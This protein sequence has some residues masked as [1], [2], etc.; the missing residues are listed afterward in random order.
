[1]PRAAVVRRDAV[2]L[3]RLTRARPDCLSKE[4][5]RSGP[6]EAP[7]IG[8]RESEREILAKLKAQTRVELNQKA[9]SKLLGE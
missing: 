2:G 5:R 9:W 8:D 7:P 6:A 3:F 4:G 1:M